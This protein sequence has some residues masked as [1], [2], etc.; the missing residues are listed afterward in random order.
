MTE[1]KTGVK[2]DLLCSFCHKSQDAVAVLISSPSDYPRAYICDECVAVCGSILDDHKNGK[3]RPS[4]S[5][6]HLPKPMEQK[7]TL[8]ELLIGKYKSK[9]EF[10]ESIR[11]RVNQR[12]KDHM[13]NTNPA[14]NANSTNSATEVQKGALQ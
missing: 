1:V 13:R 9:E 8:A 5:T 14:N 2:I 11:D 12:L 7:E 6:T 10:R 3:I 4:S